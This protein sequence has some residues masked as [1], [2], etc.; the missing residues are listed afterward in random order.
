[1]L[2]ERVIG[3]EVFGRVPGYDTGNDP[4]VRSRA[5]EVR[6]RLAQHYMQEG[7]A[8]S[9]VRI[10]VPSGSYHATFEIREAPLLHEDAAA[11]VLG[12]EPLAKIGPSVP[13]F[14][15]VEYLVPQSRPT[16][17]K[18]Y[19]RLSLILVGILAIAGLIQLWQ[20]DGRNERAFNRFWGP[21]VGSPN[22][23][24]VYFGGTYS[25]HLSAKSLD[26]YRSGRHLQSAESGVIKNLENGN[27]LNERSLI[28]ENPL[29]GYGDAAA[30]ARVASTVTHLGRKYDLRYGSDIAITDLRSSNAILIG[31]FSNIWTLQL[32]HDFRYT[33]DQG[34]IVDR[35][36]QKLAWIQSTSSDG[37]RD[38]DY[39]VVSRILNSETGSFTL[40][41]AGINTY[42]NLAA[43]DFVCDPERILAVTRP[44]KDGWEKKNIQ[45]VLHTTVTNQVPFA[46]DV[47]A[48]YSW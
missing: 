37:L 7:G 32:M 8:Q 10:D 25:Y 26:D 2:R 17:K 29:I 40:I 34:G 11:A 4:V 16:D 13:I 45:I 21:V 18:L 5:A 23:V 15:P 27:M 35:Q 24:V 39:V 46:A 22:A 42:S 19:W 31:G 20:F 43:A 41:I 47:V 30:V 14:S 6:K 36:R 48:V 3:A 1:M 28:P 38:E 12:S 33:L 9:A 44:M